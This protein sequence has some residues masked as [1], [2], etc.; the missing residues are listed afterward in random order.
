MFFNKKFYAYILI[1]C[2]FSANVKAQL[3][4]KILSYDLPIS[5]AD[6]NKLFFGLNTLN[7]LRN[8]EYFGSI[9]SGKTTFGY[10]LNPKLTYY[11]TSLIRIDFGGFFRKDFGNDKFKMVSP[12]FSVK[13][14]KNGYSAIFGNYEAAMCH[15]LI[16]PL[17]NVEYAITKPL[18]NGFQFKIDKKR[19]F[20]DTWVDWQKM[21]YNASPFKEEIMAGTSNLLTVIGAENNFRTAIAYQ[22]VIRHVGGQIDALRNTPLLTDVNMATGLR[23]SYHF[24]DSSFFK[25][26]RSDNYFVAYSESS[27]APV[28]PYK[29]GSGMYF[30]LLLK[31]KV[32]SLMASYW[33]ASNYVATNGTPIYQS[34]NSVDF[35]QAVARVPKRELLFLRFFYE[36]NLAKDLSLDVRFEPFYEFNRKTVDFSYSVYLR[37]NLNVKLANIKS[38]IN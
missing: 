35:N 20:S 37:Y 6:S 21:I 14:A 28:N 12:T 25:E 1:A 23:L 30:N 24:E 2:F 34:I 26:L 16:E 17:F 5:G 32:I 29:N 18:E 31:T 3:D 33:N 11:P 27:S 8:T 15:R 22:A 4:N 10:F 19:L 7:Y 9:E 36:K 38:L 13:I